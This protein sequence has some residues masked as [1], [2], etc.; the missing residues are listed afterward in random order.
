[1]M[2]TQI[3]EYEKLPMEAKTTKYRTRRARQLIDTFFKRNII[4]SFY[5]SI[6]DHNL[7]YGLLMIEQLV[8]NNKYHVMYAYMKQ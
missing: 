6:T 5:Q 7:I 8:A 2:M 1:M 4:S 3:D